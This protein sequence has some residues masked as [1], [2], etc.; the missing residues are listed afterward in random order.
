M[1]EKNIH[2]FS[3][4]ISQILSSIYNR[5]MDVL[6]VDLKKM[7]V[8]RIEDTS[9]E[10]GLLAGI[11]L[12]RE[13]GDDSLVLTAPPSSS[14]S[15]SSINSWS[16]VWHSVILGRET[17]ATSNS[18]HGYSLFRLGIKAMVILGR[19]ERMKY[20]VLSQDKVDF[21]ASENLKYSSSRS[22]EEIA[23]SSL[24]DLSPKS[25]S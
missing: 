18:A 15:S 10:E 21:I 1:S 14:V 6:L 12:H 20:L 4:R 11:R 2:L 7:S 22:F 17:Y 3:F 8:E 5:I 19:N 13:Y 16:I 9:N 24:S 23:L 25:I